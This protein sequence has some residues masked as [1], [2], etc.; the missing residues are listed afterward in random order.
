VKKTGFY[1]SKFCWQKKYILAKWSILCM[2]KD[3]GGAG[4]LE[5]ENIDFKRN[6][7]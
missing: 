4:G 1:H 2:P 7:N 6:S 5:I 3:Q